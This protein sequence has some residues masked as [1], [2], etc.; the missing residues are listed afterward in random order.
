MFE[1]F[2]ELYEAVSDFDSPDGWVQGFQF[3]AEMNAAALEIMAYE[4]SLNSIDEDKEDR[5]RERVRWADL[6]DED[7]EEFLPASSASILS[8]LRKQRGKESIMNAQL[9]DTHYTVIA[10]IHEQMPSH[11]FMSSDYN[12][13]SIM[14]YTDR[15]IT[16]GK[17]EHSLRFAAYAEYRAFISALESEGYFAQS[18]VTGLM[19]RRDSMRIPAS[20]YKPKQD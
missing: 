3:G 4:N 7:E 18:S 10:A 5:E 9:N 17:E 20:V 12:T 8:R 2:W 6:E 19:F 14:W 16:G 15:S 11:L 13:H 1:K